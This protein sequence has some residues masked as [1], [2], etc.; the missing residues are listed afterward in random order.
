MIW[1]CF[2]VPKIDLPL[3]QVVRD[4]FIIQGQLSDARNQSVVTFYNLNN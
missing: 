3:R 2:S 4:D 1:N